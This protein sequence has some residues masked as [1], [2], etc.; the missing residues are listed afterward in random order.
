MTWFKIYT[1]HDKKFRK[2]F[3]TTDPKRADLVATNEAKKICNHEV[4]V[5][6]TDDNGITNEIK[7]K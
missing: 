4:K 2:C 1:K 5:V 7:Y 6:A 3:A